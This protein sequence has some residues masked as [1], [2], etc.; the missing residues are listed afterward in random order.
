MDAWLPAA[1]ILVLL[2]AVGLGAFSYFRTPK[3]YIDFAKIAFENLKPVVLQIL[4]KRMSPEKEKELHE[5][6]RRGGEWDP[7]RKRCKNR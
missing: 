7:V 4:L 1:F 3:P 6:L 5:C 2:I